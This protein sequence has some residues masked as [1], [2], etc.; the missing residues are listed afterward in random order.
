MD[1]HCEAARVLKSLSR[2]D[3]TRHLW[4]VFDVYPEITAVGSKAGKL[5]FRRGPP[6]CSKL[7]IR[8]VYKEED[9]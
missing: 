9:H 8:K 6:H 5:N 3:L 4:H 2:T 1:C 7:D